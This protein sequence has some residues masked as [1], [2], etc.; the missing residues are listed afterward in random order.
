MRVRVFKDNEFAA[1]AEGEGLTDE[2]LCE[3]AAEVERGLVNARLGGFLIKKRIGAPGGGKRGGFR[4]IIAHRQGERLI[5][6]HGFRKNE[7]DNISK[8]EKKALQKLGDQYMEYKGDQ[9]SQ[10]VREGLIIEV[11]CE[12]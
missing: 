8:K 10:L 6:L 1:W 11:R 7:Q 9:M 3:A 5:F 2:R 12:R 4:T